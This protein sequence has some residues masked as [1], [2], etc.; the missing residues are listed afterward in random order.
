M[1]IWRVILAG[2]KLRTAHPSGWALFDST[3]HSDQ[4]G[5]VTELLRI[6]TLRAHAGPVTI[7]QENLTRSARNVLRGMHYQV[8]PPQGKLVRVLQG[9][10]HDVIVDLRRGSPWFGQSFDTDLRDHHSLMLWV[11]PGFAHGF[12]AREDSLVLYAL[13]RPWDPRLDRAI[14]WDSAALAIDWPLEDGEPIV[15]EK[16]RAAPAFAHA[17]VFEDDAG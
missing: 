13:T 14:R 4:R 10:L 8:G 9:R 11:P 15:S 1:F 3:V 2:M 5:W 16:D 12:L 7:A 6:E 17:E